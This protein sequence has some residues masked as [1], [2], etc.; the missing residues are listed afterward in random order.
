MRYDARYT[1]Y[2]Q[3]LG[4]L[5]FIHMVTRSTPAFNPAAITAL[6]DRWRPETHTFHLRTGET[7][8]TLQD[9]SMILALPIEGNPV[10]MSS[11]SDGWREEMVSLIGKDPPEAINKK[12][13]KLRVAAGAT[14]TW[15]IQNFKICPEDAD[16][17]T[18]KT[19]TRVYVWYIITRTLFPD[20]SG[21]RAQWHWLKL[22]VFFDSTF[23][24]GS[25][26]L[27]WLYRQVMSYLQMLL[28]ISALSQKKL[29]L[30]NGCSLHLQLDD[31]CLRSAAD[32]GIGGCLLLLSVWS[33]E[34]FSIGRPRLLSFN[35]YID[36]GNDYLLPTWAYK[37][38]VVSEPPTDPLEAYKRYTNE[39]D[40]ITMD[41]VISA[42][43]VNYM[44]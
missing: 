43:A 30:P 35:P 14:F 8:I 39:F 36:N 41:Q 16:E 21:D 10:C 40:T 28:Y 17:E 31:A 19:Y 29:F 2:I 22:L 11:D 9:M 25:A 3:Q 42:T 32:S 38:D 23:S 24:W 26:A 5:P 44:S 34:H 1:P 15:I 7:T 27:A 33:W 37:W 6:V 4:L 18:I 13:E 20:S 12:G